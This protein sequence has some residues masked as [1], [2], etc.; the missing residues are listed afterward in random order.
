MIWVMVD[1]VLVIVATYLLLFAGSVTSCKIMQKKKGYYYKTNHFISLSSMIYRMK[2]NGAGLAS[3]CILSTMVLVMVS[4]TTSL[5]LRIE[6]G[7]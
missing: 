5:Y 3:I 4:S 7:L 1:V 2:R 6:H